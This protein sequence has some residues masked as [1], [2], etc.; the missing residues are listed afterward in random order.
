MLYITAVLALSMVSELQSGARQVL[1]ASG[2][3]TR[4]IPMT[5]IYTLLTMEMDGDRIINLYSVT[6]YL[7][8]ACEK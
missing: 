7:H 6:L 4:D 8:V 1:V 3:Q 5:G 2:T